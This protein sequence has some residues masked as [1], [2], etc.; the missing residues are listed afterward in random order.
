MRIDLAEA[1]RIAS[2]ARLGLGDRELERMAAEMSG[3]LGYIDQL[4]EVDTGEA[5]PDSPMMLSL[6]ED[7]TAATLDRDTVSANA[8]QWENDCFVVPRVIGE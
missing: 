8:P 3:I 1:R 2:L 7:V 4:A 5:P 6:R